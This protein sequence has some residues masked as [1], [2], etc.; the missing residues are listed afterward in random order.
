MRKS[1]YFVFIG[2]LFLKYF[3][4]EAQESKIKFGAYL[5]SYY[6]YD[7]SK[8]L[9]NRL[10]VTQ[11]D[12]HNEFNLNHAILSA[13]YEGEK[14][15]ANLGVHIGTYPA[16]NYSAE[17]EKFYQNIYEAYAGYQVTDKSWLDIG[18]FGGH[19]GYESALGL[20]RELYSPALA[21]EYTPYYQSGA[22]YTYEFS[23]NTQL[24]AV[25]L[26]GWQN[27][28]ETNAHKS[29]GLAI[30]HQLSD[31]LMI[32]YGN[33]YGNESTTDE[34]VMRLHNN[35]LVSAELTDGLSLTGVLDYTIQDQPGGDDINAL[36]LTFIGSYQ[37]ADQWSAAG[38]YEYV[39][40]ED[41]ILITGITGSFKVNVYSLALSHYATE[42]AAIKLE[43][44]IYDGPERNFQGE[45]GVGP[46]LMTVNLGIMV[47]I[48]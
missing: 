1:I 23:E 7:F 41:G 46:G 6:S 12:R 44:K 5:D 22:R 40:D 25:V 36:F 15:R 9:S 29:F 39:S 42:N 37:L 2:V 11:Y 45:E 26:N 13:A 34:D 33:Y 48:E 19:F 32:S 24:R 14:I 47:R 20:D 31:Q 38:R 17:P 21:T 27:I 18:V 16:N 3:N 10:Y 28:G 35:F 30:D 8:P 4:A 43:G